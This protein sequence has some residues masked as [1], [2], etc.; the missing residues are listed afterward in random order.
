MRCRR[1][2]VVA[3][4]T[5]AVLPML[6]LFA[7][8]QDDTSIDATINVEAQP[9]AAALKDFSDQTGLQ[10]AYVAT[11]AENKTSNGVEN[12][13]SPV[14]ALDAILDSTGL[15]YQ[16]VNEETVAIGLTDGRGGSDSK[17]SSPVPVLMAQNQ[18][19]RAQTTASTESTRRGEEGTTSVVTGRVTDARTGANLKG[20]KVSIEETGQ[21]TSTNDLGEFRFVNVPTGNATLTVSYLGYAGQSTGIAV[22]G[23]G[24]SQDFALRGGG[25]IE[26]IVVFGQRSA[27]AQAINMERTAENSTTVLSADLLGRFEGATIAEAL[28]KAPGMAFQEDELTGEGTNI[29]VR[30][31]APDLNQIRFDGL[32]LA[33]GSGIGR[34]PSIGNILTDSISEVTISKTLLPSQD[35]SGTGGLVEITTQGPFDR[36]RRYFSASLEGGTTDDFHDAVQASV[37]ASAILGEKENFGVSA[38]LQYRD[39]SNQTVRFGLGADVFGQYL[40]LDESG[41][42]IVSPLNVNPLD[43][44]PFEV[45]ADEVYPGRVDNELSTVDNEIFAG[46]FALQWRPF[47]HTDLKLSYTRTG[48]N[49]VST[50]T[51]ARFG[52]FDQYIV[53]PIPDLGGEQRAAIVWQDAAAGFGFP[54]LF[55]TISHEIVDQDDDL[56]SDILSFQGETKLSS[57]TLNYSLGRTTAETNNNSNNWSYNIA[58]NTLSFYD[59]P[60]SFLSEQARNNTINGLV[61]SVFAPLSGNGFQ[62]AL[63]SDEGFEFFN[64]PSNY[65]VSPSNGIT[66]SRSVG[67]NER[68]SGRF[69]IRRDFETPF[70]SYIEAGVEYESARFDREFS[71]TLLYQS[72]VG[73]LALSDLGFTEFTGN[74]LSDIGASSGFFGLLPSDLNR[75]F[76]DLSSLSTGASPLLIQSEIGLS[77]LSDNGTF[78]DEDELAAYVQVSLKF[79]DLEVVGGFRYSNY[80]T[81]SRSLR[82]P[83][84]RLADGSFDTIFQ[85]SFRELV[86]QEADQTE[87]LPRVVINYRPS[88]NL[89][90]RGGYYQS[91]ARPRIDD[92]TQ[93]QNVSLDLRPQYGAAGNQPLL[94]IRQGNPDLA[95]TLTHSYDLSLQYYDENAGVLGVSFFYKDIQDFVEFTSDSDVDSIAGIPL[96]DDSRFQNLPSD[97]FIQ[98]RQPVNND[99]SARIWG[100]E[101]SAE[102]QF[103]NLPGVWSGLGI[104]ANYT[105]SDSEK[106]YVFE[107]VFDPV[108]GE[109]V[110][111]EVDGVRFDQ[112]PE[113]SGTFAVTYN[114]YGIDAS[115]SYTAQSE[116]LRSIRGNNLSFYN[117]SDD[118]LDARFEYRIDKLGGQWRFFIAGSDLLKGK[119]DPDTLQYQ[120]GEGR[121]PKFYSSGTFFGGRTVSAGVATVF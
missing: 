106:Y 89:V 90:V 50:R 17:N 39:S 49:T 43:P 94:S 92:L 110:D 105:H 104:Y 30:G 82:V 62:T 29:I 64:D 120:G 3:I 111:V 22:Y 56:N 73:D 21:W 70:I 81:T 31:L 16:F 69:S 98:V 15:E 11:L 23:E 84:L 55:T 67:S 32:R 41:Q 101:L 114:K 75:L 103:V 78:T 102:R 33:E 61:V 71:P 19:S 20:A 97:I 121:T 4:A 37:A 58:P 53:Q 100:V 112:S 24:T 91:I 7:L 109:F 66:Q 118:S 52:T 47:D 115:V 74:N 76:A 87:I 25:E 12:A 65:I 28:R 44:F 59:V 113:H 88:E 77:S 72:A 86:D 45:G 35:S 116:R 6:S 14:D 108:L 95:P 48:Q 80:Q 68:T 85:E 93:R 2:N 36:S 38:S 99:R 40:P 96:P 107:D 26:E 8:A 51:L 34:S 10:L 54:G 119:S 1:T 79:G 57:W 5:V 27:R 60:L 18:T 9:L 83:S 42:P 117:D 46:T 13:A 63:L